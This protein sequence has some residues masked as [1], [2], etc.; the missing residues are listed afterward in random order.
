MSSA[1]LIIERKEQILSFAE[2]DKD[3]GWKMKFP[4]VIF[5]CM[6][7]FL[8]IF[9]KPLLNMIQNVAYGVF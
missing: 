3:P 7:F 2:N 1:L 8:G 9:A 4:I 6:I 5:A